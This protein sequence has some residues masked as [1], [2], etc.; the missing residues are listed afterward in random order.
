MLY[1][2]K[3]SCNG[4]EEITNIRCTKGKVVV[5]HHTITKRLKKFWSELQEPRRS[6]K[7]FNDGFQSRA[8]SQFCIPGRK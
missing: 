4:T 7:A 2:F 1:G 8:A 6:A 5:D 3:F